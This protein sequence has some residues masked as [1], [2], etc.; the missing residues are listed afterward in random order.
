MFVND[1]IM[2][3]R[4]LFLF[5]NNVR[6]VKL[7]MCLSTRCPTISE[8]SASEAILDRPL[9]ARSEAAGLLAAASD[10]ISA[11]YFSF[12]SLEFL[13]LL[14]AFS[15]DSPDDFQVMTNVSKQTSQLGQLQI[16]Q[17]KLDPKVLVFW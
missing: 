9:S 6:G 3:M 10:R 8:R 14:V 16:P 17:S 5:D 1:E 15:C 13:L 4:S 12:A 11:R 2:M 7:A